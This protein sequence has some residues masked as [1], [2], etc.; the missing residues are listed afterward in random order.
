VTGVQTC[1]LPICPR[2]KILSSKH[3]SRILLSKDS[4]S[5]PNFSIL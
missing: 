2:L 1:A 4:L 3:F 5:S